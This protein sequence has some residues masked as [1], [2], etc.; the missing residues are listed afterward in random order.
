MLDKKCLKLFLLS[1][2]KLEIFIKEKPK[3]KFFQNTKLDF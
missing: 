3:E 2:K 1:F